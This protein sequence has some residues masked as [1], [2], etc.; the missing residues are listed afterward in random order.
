MTATVPGPAAIQMPPARAPAIVF[1]MF[2]Q[3]LYG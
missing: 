3:Q 2:F 1:G